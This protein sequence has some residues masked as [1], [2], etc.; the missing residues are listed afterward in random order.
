MTIVAPEHA[1]TTVYCAVWHADPDRHELLRSHQRSLQVQTADV[2]ALYVFDAGDEPPDWLE[3]EVAVA[4][5]PLTIYQAWNVATQLAR[6]E[7]VMNLNLDDRLVPGAVQVLQDAIRANEAALVGGEWRVCFDQAATDAAH[8]TGSA[9]QAAT[10]LPFTPQ[11]PPTPPRE[12]RLGSGTGD[13][14]TR[15]P[16]T[17]WRRELHDRMPYPHAFSDGAP[18]LSVGDTAWWLLVL[19]YLEGTA[20]RVPVVVGHYHSH[21]GDQ[22]EFRVTDEVGRLEGGVKRG[23]HPLDRVRHAHA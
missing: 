2:A 19:Q 4:Q 10:E 20:V 17:I 9:L 11:W 1:T 3:G 14:G 15:G 23:N 7:L 8:D 5:E 13:R 12:V 16:G 18:I 21:P 6:T 22:A